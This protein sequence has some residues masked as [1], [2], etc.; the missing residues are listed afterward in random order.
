MKLFTLTLVAIVS[1]ALALPVAA[2]GNG[3]IS[4]EGLKAPPKAANQADNGYTRGC[5]PYFQCRGGK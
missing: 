1:G 2:P 5:N 3:H 4:Y